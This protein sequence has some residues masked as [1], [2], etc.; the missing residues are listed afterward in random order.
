VPGHRIYMGSDGLIVYGIAQTRTGSCKKNI[1]GRVFPVIRPITGKAPIV[2]GVNRAVAIV[3]SATGTNGTDGLKEVKAQGGMTLVQTPE[4][5]K[6]DGMPRSAISAD[7]ADPYSCSSG[8]AG[9]ARS[10]P[11][12]RLCRPAGWPGE[13]AN[14][15][16]YEQ[17][18]ALLHARSGTDFR[19]HKRSKLG[20]RIHRRLGLRHIATWTITLRSFSPTPTRSPRSSRIV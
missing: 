1:G 9:L 19:S 6:F 5:A 7:L 18:L 11:A 17:V 20:R 8:N 3:L 10:L 16:T 2:C 4:T 15:A 14:G 12:R 13:R